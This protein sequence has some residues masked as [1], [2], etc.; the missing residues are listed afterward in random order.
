[1]LTIS[2]S[3]SASQ[4]QTYH[5]QDFASETQSYYRQGIGIEGEWQGPTRHAVWSVGCGF[6]RLNFSG[7]RKGCTRQRSNPWSAR[8]PPSSTKMPMAKRPRASSTAQDGMRPFRLPS[9]FRSRLLSAAMT[10][11]GKPIAPPLPKLLT[12]LNGTRKPASA[13][14]IRLK[15]PTNS[16]PAKFEHD[17]ARPVAGY[18]APQLHTHAV[19]FNVTERADGTTRALQERGL[20]ESQQ[21]A[22]AVYQS[23]LTYWLRNLGYE[24]ER[25]KSGAPEIKGYTQEYLDVSS[26]RSR[27]IREQLEK[28]GRAGA[29]AA[30]IAA[31]STRDRKQ[32]LTA[33][34]VLDAHRKMAAEFGNQ[35]EKVVVAAHERTRR[36]H[37]QLE[38]NAHA[39]EAV[40]FARQ[41]VFEREAVADERRIL[42]DAMRREMGETTYKEIRSEFEA[43]RAADDF[44]AVEAPKYSSGRRFTTPETI[45]AECANIGFMLRGR[46]AVEPILS[47]EQA[48]E[49]ARS[50]DFLNEAQRRVIEETLNST[51]RVHGLQGRGRNR[52]DERACLD[53]RR[54]GKEWL[55][56]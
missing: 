23:E 14:T 55:C 37:V 19:I 24:I 5:K 44:K 46:N 22:T 28:T 29:E 7:S 31:H 54:R 15:R 42:R 11:S 2:K 4:A 34:E 56:G 32:S 39:R 27:Q 49:Q 10:G 26:P 20:F 3:L 36:R 16:L 12:R 38:S 51:D 43:R 8:A 25:G 13:A 47:A 50:R 30:E 52:E 33:A 18:A 45:A 35:P 17:T 41:S 6:H 9:R 53:P 40:T 48:Q 21:F 1:M